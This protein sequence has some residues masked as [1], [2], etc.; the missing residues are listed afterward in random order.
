M[1][2]VL[3]LTKLPSRS[4]TG[5]CNTPQADRT[6]HRKPHKAAYMTVAYIYDTV[7]PSLA[8]RITSAGARSFVIVKKI[9]GRAQR[10][11]LGR[12]PGLEL[13]DAR[14]AAR[15]IAGEIAKGD[16]PVAL[17]RAARARKTRLADLWPSLPFAFEATK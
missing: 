17:R 2:T 12:S 4:E 1:S 5:P 16:D 8:L 7:A 14:Q 9:N 15:T 13:D 6:A 3:P 11:T 10:I